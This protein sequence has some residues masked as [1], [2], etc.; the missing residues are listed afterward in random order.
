[1]SV[2]LKKHKMNFFKNLFKKIFNTS[3][4]T[5]D[6][7][8]LIDTRPTEEKKED[9]HISEIVAGTAMVTY[10]ELRPD[11]IRVF[12][13]QDQGWK[14]DCVA[15]S[16]RKLKRILFKVNKNLTLDFSSVAFYR[17]RANFPSGGMASSDAIALDQ[18]V[19]MTLDALVPSDELNTESLANSVAPEAYNDDVAGVFRT[20]NK[21][22][23]FTPGDLET[24]AGTIQKTRK[25]VMMW[26]FFTSTEWSAEVPIIQDYH[27]DLYAPTTLRHSV[28]GI[29]PALYKGQ[30]GIWIDDSAHFGGLSRRFITEDFYKTRN[31][32][33]S[34]PMS[35]RFEIDKGQRPVFKDGNVISLQNCL[36]FE[37][38]FP[39]NI[40]STGVYGSITRQAVKDFQKKYSLEQVGTVGPKTR[41]KL[42]ELYNI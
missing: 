23:N 1:M 10:K 37:G 24:P 21:D 9:H 40:D 28:V 8:A 12:G 41:Q 20:A 42:L 25:G 17:K 32:F 29:E 18:N 13:I 34:Y 27:L 33:A 22:I 35:F 4:E 38:V 16:R 2:C 36:K 30:K 7:G 39:T 15:E 26:F 19:G 5:F 11:E 31:W 3:P 14:S 6:L